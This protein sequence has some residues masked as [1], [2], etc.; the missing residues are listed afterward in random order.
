MTDTASDRPIPVTD[1]HAQRRRLG[2]GIEGALRRVL[3]HGRFLAGPEIE[4]LESR[5]ASRAG[6]D[7]A[8][9]CASGTD[10]LMMALLAL[11]ARPGDSVLVPGFTF[12]ATAEAVALIGATP[13]FLDVRANDFNMDPAAIAAGVAAAKEAGLR[14]V[15]VI[16]V[17]LFGHP[18]DY[19]AIEPAAEEHGLWLVCDAAQSYGACRD[20]R[21]A[22]SIG[23]IATTSFYP[24]K[25]LGCYGDGGAVMTGDG[26]LAEAMLELRDHGRSA[27]TGMHARVG[28]TGRIDTFQA[29]V[30]L[31]K[32]AVFDE[33][34]EMRGR[35]AERY[36]EMIGR[37]VGDAVAPAA[38]D[39]TVST[40]AQYT[41]RLPAD[42]R[43]AVQGRMAQAGVS[44]AVHYRTPLHR[45]PAY[46]GYPVAGGSLPVAEALAETVLSLPM[47][48]YLPEG[49]QERV[50]AAMAAAMAEEAQR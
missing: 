20:G 6:A 47:H 21:K 8:I 1:L 13:V 32:L 14:P 43:D 37:D 36:R 22:G 41:V 5:L 50:V 34:V 39:G 10:A 4:E 31:E 27:A 42:R 25:P 30:L 11:G 33:E 38:H 46:S 24:S 3:E 48:A 40:W 2:D 16:A 17:D 7:H 45:Q 26:V 15:G 23:A 19:A 44:T 49:D 35:V 9:A 29:A 12:V 28:L 18:A